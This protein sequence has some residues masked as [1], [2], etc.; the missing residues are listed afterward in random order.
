MSQDMRAASNPSAEDRDASEP[1]V[2]QFSG[3]DRS[4]AGCQSQEEDVGFGAF[5]T[6]MLLLFIFI[7]LA[8][9]QQ[10]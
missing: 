1:N 5:K 8:M 9:L 3:G 6:A 10:N 2:N 4:D 7:V